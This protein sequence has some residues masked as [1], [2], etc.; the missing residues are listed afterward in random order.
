MYHH[1]IPETWRTFCE[2]FLEAHVLGTHALLLYRSA[3]E[4]GQ[5][6][7]TTHGIEGTV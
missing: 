1:S 6:A 2:L 4:G 5:V 3:E 7:L